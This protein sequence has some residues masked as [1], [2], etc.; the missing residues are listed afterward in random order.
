[1]S[2]VT[3]L[4]LHVREGCED[5]LVATFKE[6]RTWLPPARSAGSCRRSCCGRLRPAARSS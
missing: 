2:T 1:M 3:V 5:A 6:H 4:R